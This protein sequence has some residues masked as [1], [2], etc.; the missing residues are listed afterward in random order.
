MFVQHVFVPYAMDFTILLYDLLFGWSLS[1][2]FEV[3]KKLW[4][5]FA[6]KAFKVV[7]RLLLLPNWEEAFPSRI[8]HQF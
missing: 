5:Y 4:F 3:L 6:D 1:F 7:Y 2:G 8:E